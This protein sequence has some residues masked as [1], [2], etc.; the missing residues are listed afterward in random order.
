MCGICGFT[1]SADPELLAYMA[2]LLTHRGPDGDG[3]Y[4]DPTGTVHLAHR[5]LSIIDLEGGA[6]PMTNE[7]GSIW[8]VFNGEIYNYKE[9]RIELIGKGHVFSTD[10]DT[11]TIIHLYEDLGEELF[12]RL[13]GMF[14]FAIWDQKKHRLLLGRDRLG[15]KP[16]Y[17]TN[18][19][20]GLAFAS[21]L[22]SLLCGPW[23]SREIDPR[24][25]SLYLS[26][27]SVPEPF[28]IYKDA[29]ALLPG[30]YLIWDPV[31]EPVIKRYW[32]IDF[33]HDPRTL[34]SEDELCDQLEELLLDATKL[35]MR[36]DV[37]V[38]AYLSGGV[39]S[40]LVVSMARR[41]Y[42]GSLNT[43][44]LGYADDLKDKNDR[45]FA[46]MM[47][48]K[49][50]TLHHEHIMHSSELVAGLD[51]VIRHLD[52]PFSGV[53]ST[54]FLTGLVC[55]HVKVVLSGDGADDQFGSYGH[56]RLAL[57]LRDLAEARNRG[58]SNPYAEVDLGPLQ[59]KEDF[60]RNFEGLAPWEIRTHFGA[61]PDADKLQLL[62]PDC[63]HWVQ[64]YSA[65]SFMRRFWDQ[66]TAQDP[67]NALL[68]ADVQT[69]LP[70]EVL[71][72]V[73]RLS[74]AHSVEVRSPFLDYRVME[75]S[76]KV[77]G[78]LKIKGDVLK[79]ILK[80]TASRYLPKEIIDRPKE[81]FVLPNHVWLRNGALDPLLADLLSPAALGAS[82]FFDPDFVGR[83]VREH[84]DG[85]REHA[86]RIWTIV[87]FQ[88]WY[89]AYLEEPMWP[90]P[91]LGSV[92]AAA[93]A[94]ERA[95]HR[96]EV[97]K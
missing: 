94:A 7:D 9:L 50:G 43:F 68:E 11:E 85:V 72:F 27:R 78:N 37:P 84:K 77:P 75:F 16:L 89:R 29:K 23:L 54:Y 87:I 64:E 82:G 49:L 34:P 35:R 47:A 61:F 76:A 79:Y 66:G 80:R 40:S 42:S 71:F 55:K 65:A 58:V 51:D 44:S 19:R 56:H 73:D 33:T 24:A 26:F 59:G 36:S 6:Q 14:A 63:K 69:L 41:F 81:G 17:W 10:S 38:G 88:A 92:Q 97:A 45:R 20:R 62:S 96:P 25:M 3:F 21:E 32:T 28:T 5:R 91:H 83:I 18:T 30:C 57:V 70:N 93:M 60:V 12:H 46:R 53:I 8:I 48:Q 2:S 39:D 4:S 31:S 86:F 90:K 15:V 22:K 95:Q 52:Q 13:N 1:G 74:M 67:L